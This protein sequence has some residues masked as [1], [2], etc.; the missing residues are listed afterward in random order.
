MNNQSN[1]PQNNPEIKKEEKVVKTPKTPVEAPKVENPQVT[2]ISE[3]FNLIPEMSK[4]EKIVEKTKSTVSIGSVVSLIILVVISLLVV[5]FNILSKQI[6]NTRSGQLSSAESR[7]RQ[8]VDKLNANEE[9]ISRA[10]LYNKVKEGAFSHRGIIEFFSRMGTKIGDVQIRSVMISEELQ[11]E[12]SGNTTN[13]ETLSKLWYI[14]GIDE[15]IQEVNLASVSKNNNR[16]NF[17]FEGVLDGK[18]FYNQN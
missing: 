10:I 11:F 16:V 7:V 2:N 6:L 8:Q 14:L 15:N 4:E 9:I 12:Y 1:Q 18:N 5:G 3:G 17:S 13:L